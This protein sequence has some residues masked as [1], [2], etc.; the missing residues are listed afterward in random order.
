MPVS[1]RKPQREIPAAAY[2]RDAIDR[3]RACGR[4]STS[5]VSFSPIKSREAASLPGIALPLSASGVHQITTETRGLKE[6]NPQITLK[7]VLDPDSRAGGE[8]LVHGAYLHVPF[9]FHKCH[10]CDFYSIVDSQDRQAAFVNRLIDEMQAASPWIRHSLETM[11]VGGGTPTL[12]RTDLWKRLLDAMAEFLPLAGEFTV[13]ANPETVTDELARVLVEGGVNRVSIGAQSFD[14]RHLK[15]LERWH[16]PANVRR[17]VEILRDAGIDNLNLD[18]IF[19]VPGQTVD[20]WRRDLDAALAL[21]PTHISCY[22]LMYEHNTPLTKRMQAGEITPVDQDIEAAMYEAVIEQLAAAGFEHYE[23][24]N[25]ARRASG[26]TRC[27]H[28]LLYWRNRNWW[29][30]G[31]SAS[32]HL[33][34]LR[35]KNIARLGEY[36]E[37]ESPLPPI[38]DVERVDQPTRAGEQFMLGLRLVEGLLSAEV[39]ALLARSGPRAAARQ[40]AIEGHLRSGLL[41]MRDDRLRLTR[42]GLLLANDVLVD[43]V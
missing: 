20:D 26:D 38:M 12:L 36:L 31:P 34:G 3:R 28:N 2:D 24:S 19:A 41:E 39:Q 9:C 4:S 16:D 27:R 8:M 23:I 5:R 37:C 22:G 43:L 18:L 42:R 40:A 30:F 33:D 14:A 1:L 25:W 32:G 6:K 35:W 10:Y 11:F 15:A 29:A 17:S 13:E 21:E 7:S